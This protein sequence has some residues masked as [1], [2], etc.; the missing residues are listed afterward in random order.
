MEILEEFRSLIPQMMKEKGIEDYEID[1]TG[2]SGIGDGYMG[3]IIFFKVE[4][5]TDSKTHHLVMKL[6]KKS[7][8]LRMNTNLIENFRREI[9]MYNTVFKSIESYFAK[10]KPTVKVLEYV[11]S[12]FWSCGEPGKEAL[13]FNNLKAD[14]FTSWKK[15]EPLDF[16]HTV[17]VVRNIAKW[18]GEVM[19]YRD[20]NPDQFQSWIPKLQNIRYELLVQLGLM[21]HAHKNFRKVVQ[22]LEEGGES[23]LAEKFKS[24]QNNL[25]QY[26]Q[27]AD[28]EKDRLVITHADL[29]INNILFKFQENTSTAIENKYFDFQVANVNTPVEDLTFF[30]YGHCDDIVLDKIDLV[31]HDYYNTLSQTVKKL[32]SDPENIFSYADLLKHWKKYGIFGVISSIEIIKL[33]LLLDEEVPNL[34]TISEGQFKDI[35][36]VFNFDMKNEDLYFQR[37]LTLFRHFGNKFL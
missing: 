20:Q 12:L 5:K 26:A 21:K 10:A 32:G 8:A 1:L 11:P 37:L 25:D 35:S 31:M 6:A 13:V 3:D 34:D 33:Q 18:H 19:A 14:G 28:D 17:Q 9:F 36:D 22:M 4:S 7:E 29:W 15:G 16:E 2:N 23:E 24:L 30:I 27:V